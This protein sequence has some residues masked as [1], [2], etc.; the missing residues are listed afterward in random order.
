MCLKWQLPEMLIAVTQFENIEWITQLVAA[1][2]HNV[3]HFDNV[4]Q[5]LFIKNNKTLEIN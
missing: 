5:V 4:S 3:N 1:G 2:Q